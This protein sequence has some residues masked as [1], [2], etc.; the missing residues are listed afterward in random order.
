MCYLF[1]SD[2]TSELSFNGSN[3][4]VT[5][6]VWFGFLYPLLWAGEDATDVR[7]MEVFLLGGGQS[8]AV[9]EEEWRQVGNEESGLSI[10]MF[11]ELCS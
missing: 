1:V 6:L 9:L 8:Q 10:P 5:L 11:P 7:T 3:V 2:V 4:T